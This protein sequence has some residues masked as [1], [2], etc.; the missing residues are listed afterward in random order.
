MSG[1]VST[2]F[3]STLAVLVAFVSGCGGAPPAPSAPLSPP[4]IGAPVSHHRHELHLPPVGPTVSVELG[5]ERAEIRLAELPHAGPTVPL[6]EVWKAAMPNRD[7]ASFD[8]DLFGSDGFHPGAR[9]ACA[10]LL[11]AG[12]LAA[13]HLDVVTHDVSFDPILQLPGCYRVRAVVR[14]EGIPIPSN[15]ARADTIATAIAV[16]PPACSAADWSTRRL[17]PILRPG[18]TSTSS[19]QERPGAAEHAFESECTDAPAGPTWDSPN[20]VVIDGVELALSN[21]APAGVSRRGWPGNQCAFDVRAADGSGR[22]TRLGPKEVPPFTTVSAVVRLGSAA[23]I[24]LSFNGYASEFPRGG[25]RV[26]AVDLC[27]G[28]IVWETKDSMSNGG[29]LLLGDYLVSPYGFTNESR[30]VFV[31]DS[32]SGNVVQRLP[33]LENIC[34]STRWAPNWHEGE[35]C[36]APGQTVGAATNPRVEG[37][38][39]LVDTNTGSSSFEFR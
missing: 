39:F 31:L 4:G 17:V 8:F 38:L 6:V 10:R 29:L 35:R 1:S 15:P 9:P 20:R 3:V 34:P 37:G 33:V 30:H 18:K 12:E 36:D 19:Q 22:A 26:V 21:A 16:A 7:P 23:W 24:S 28:R 32:H 27:D 2:K 25:N 14:L 11:N 5:N 13:A